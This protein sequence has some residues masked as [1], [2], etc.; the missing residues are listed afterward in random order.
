ML[1]PRGARA[2]ARTQLAQS[3]AESEESER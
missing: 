2:A 1:G 3:F